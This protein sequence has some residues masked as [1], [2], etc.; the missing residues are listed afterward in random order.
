MKI[1]AF[2]P[3]KKN[4]ERVK[5]KN[6]RLLGDKPLYQWICNHAKECDNFDD[7]IIDSDSEEVREWAERNGFIFHRRKPHLAQ[8]T[9]NGNDLL[10]YHFNQFP[11]YDL[12]F[13]LFA[14][15]PFLTPENICYCVDKLSSSLEYDSIFTA[16]EES[17]FFWFGG[18]PLNYSPYVLP[19]SQDGKKIISESTGLYGIKRES[20]EKYRCRI[21][22]KPYIHIIPKEQSIDIDTEFDWSYANWYFNNHQLL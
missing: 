13:Q 9:A 17:G 4:S 20:L 10:N 8:N 16:T 7:I 19:R 21:G 14:T 1:S 18:C 5:G 12:Y 15:A 2:I 3:V 22:A 6:F 11:D